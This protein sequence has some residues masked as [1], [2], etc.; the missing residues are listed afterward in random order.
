M[1][2]TVSAEW[3]KLR[4]SRLAFV[5]SALPILSLLIGCANY[6]FNQTVLQ[7]E[8]Y[9]L[10]TQVSL[11]YGEF[12]LPVLIAI[13]C[14]YVCRLEH[15]NNNWNA[16][17]TSPKSIAS[18]FLAKLVVVSGLIAMVQTFFIVLYVC[19]GLTLGLSFSPPVE[20]FG[21][22][23]RGWI[24]S[25]AISAVQLMLSLRIR[26]FS[27]PIGITLCGVFVGLG[28]YVSKL[29]MF[30]PYS[31]LTIG[32][33]VLSQESLS[34]AENSLFLATTALFT[35]VFSGWAIRRL[36]RADVS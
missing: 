9:S 26:S 5:L 18:V 11:F 13:C 12:F 6:Y 19:A 16:V 14:A 1:R 29:G 27:A 24:A 34:V 2:R 15:M 33:G 22:V 23:V 30:F 3:L 17:L 4:R 10:W 31:L 36:R 25:V 20:L 21:W 35:I 28:F 32:M 8:W 7:N